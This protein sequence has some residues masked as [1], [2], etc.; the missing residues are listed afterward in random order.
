MIKLTGVTKIYDKGAAGTT[1]LKN[2]NLTV[3]S[4]EMIAIMGTSGSGKTTLLNMIGCMDKMTEGQYF[5]DD[6]EVSSLSKRRLDKFRKE[7]VSFVFQNFALMNDYTVFENAEVPL[8]CKGVGKRERKK[9]IM[10][11][12]QKVGIKELSK[13]YPRKISGGQKQRCAIAR[14]IASG[15]DLIL[16]DEPT[17]ALDKNTGN[18][19]MNLL[20]DLNE[21]GK[22][23]IIV[24][25]NKDI[26][27]QCQR[28]IYIE[29]G[30]VE[31][32]PVKPV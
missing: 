4:G 13:K 1:A 7:H 16:A 22:T 25:H 29:D 31:E 12:L 30:V 26:A 19:I 27:K 28:I 3:E 11:S 10:D 23:I 20:K 9:R 5:Y 32:T 17:G 2:V 24:T 8:L 14:A 15:N 6:V 18:E 21:Q